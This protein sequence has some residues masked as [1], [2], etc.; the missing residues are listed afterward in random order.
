VIATLFMV[1]SVATQALCLAGTRASE[2]LRRV[3]WVAV[4]LGGM[5]A[6]VV[7]MSRALAL[8]IPLAVAYG[9]W[10]GSGIALAALTGAIVFH[11]RLARVHVVGLALVLAGVLLVYA[12]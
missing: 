11:D 7:L 10:S 8:G 2:G 1:G 3:P 4:A 9:L 12:G 6:S 5:I